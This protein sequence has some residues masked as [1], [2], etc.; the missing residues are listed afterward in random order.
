MKKLLSTTW[1]RNRYALFYRIDALLT[2]KLFSKLCRCHVLL[3]SIE[4]D[5]RYVFHI[6][7]TTENKLFNFIFILFSFLGLWRMPRPRCSSW[8]STSWPNIC[9]AKL[10]SRMWQAAFSPACARAS[11]RHRETK[12]RRARQNVGNILGGA[13]C[14][15]GVVKVRISTAFFKFVA[16]PSKLVWSSYCIVYFFCFQKMGGH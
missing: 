9:A 13:C 11:F 10:W 4:H 1:D 7:Y 5:Y 12:K 6:H 15:M 2:M 14:K 8:Y 3:L 16:A